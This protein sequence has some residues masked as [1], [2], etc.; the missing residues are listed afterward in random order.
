LPD[1]S[2]L[3]EPADPGR[4]PRAVYVG[5]LR[6]SRGLFAMLDAVA[7]APGWELDLVGPVAAVDQPRLEEWLRTSPAADRVR[8]HGRLAPRE[9]WRVA[10]GAW[11]GLVLLDRTPAFEAAVP[12][13]AYEYLACGLVLLATPLPRIEQLVAESGGGVCVPDVGAVAAQLR[14]WAQDPAGLTALRAAGLAWSRATTAAS[15]YDEL[16]ARVAV[17]AGVSG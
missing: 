12:T 8:L 13:K 6:A 11:V 1:L 5:D 17:L 4:V 10:A 7:A 9:A 16:A 2:M 15:P 3:P 14:A